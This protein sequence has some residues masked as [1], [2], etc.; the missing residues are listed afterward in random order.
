MKRFVFSANIR[1]TYFFR[2]ICLSIILTI[3]CSGLSPAKVI[4][5]NSK[6]AGSNNGSSWTNAYTDLQS[7]LHA[8][9]PGDSIWVA[10]GTYYPTS[11]TDSISFQIPD[12]VKVFGGFAGNETNFNSRDYKKNVTI[13]NGRNISYHVVYFLNAGSSTALDGFT[14]KGGWT[15][16]L[17]SSSSSFDNSILGGGI[18][19]ESTSSRTCSPI[20]DNCLINGNH[21][22]EG[23]GVCIFSDTGGYSSPTLNQCNISDNDGGIQLNNSQQ[24]QGSIGAGVSVLNAGT[25]K[26]NITNCT[27]SKDSATMGGGIGIYNFGI[28]TASKVIGTIKNC[29]ISNNLGLAE[30]GGI[31]NFT[32]GTSSNPS[33]ISVTIDSCTISDNKSGSGG[34]IFDFNVEN[35]QCIPVF[36]NCKITGNTA[37]PLTFASNLIP[38]IGGGISNMDCGPGPIFTNCTISGDS[39][40]SGGGIS[41]LNTAA[42]SNGQKPFF[43][44]IFTGCKI[45]GNYA[46]NNGGGIFSMSPGDT[47][48]ASLT[49]CIISGNYANVSG[50]GIYNVADTSTYTSILASAERAVVNSNIMSTVRAIINSNITNTARTDINSNE[51]N[52]ADAV[53]NYSLMNCTITGNYAGANGGAM[54]NK[55]SETGFVGVCNTTVENSIIWNNEANHS[56][57]SADASVND[58]VDSPAFSY[59]IVANSRGNSGT[60][61]ASLGTDDGH[62]IDKDPLFKSALDPSTA[63]SSNG[64]FHLQLGS[65][66]LGAGSPVTDPG[67]PKTDIDGNPRPLPSTD[68]NVDIG[69]YE[70]NHNAT[71]IK[72]DALPGPKKFMLE[73]NYPNPFNPSTTIKY[74][75]PRAVHVTLKVYDILGNI[76]ETLV[77]NYQQAGNYAVQVGI[78]NRQFAS[79]VYIYKLQAGSFVQSKKMILLK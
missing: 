15:D 4:F 8:A 79:G 3:S 37:I 56:T 55:G 32:G 38:G 58:S 25:T 48:S 9:S 61:L 75:I 78:G 20:I 24:S 34:G 13:L 14:I 68:T 63:P 12:G 17:S 10:E 44:P 66:A 72:D 2:A 11:T 7:A 53:V 29:V 28:N 70:E 45:S 74:D 16:T 23:G 49:N 27:I 54:Y 42:S 52:A 43:T 76:V 57:T 47:L 77:N 26:L 33:I 71:N 18:L 41:N 36:A 51:M 73:Q 46:I 67:V 35:S 64:D 19:I 30:G 31:I 22:L 69:A 5:V 6:A 62:N 40:V 39:A 59:S 60:W 65:P 50:G 21:G 1:L